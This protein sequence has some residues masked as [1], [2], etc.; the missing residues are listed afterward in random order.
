MQIF[1]EKLIESKNHISEINRE[2]RLTEAL[3]QQTSRVLEKCNFFQLKSSLIFSV[4][5]GENDL[6]KAE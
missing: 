1:Q 2:K 5:K 3:S 4:L 6:A